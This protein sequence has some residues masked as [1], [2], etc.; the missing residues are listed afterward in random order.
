MSSAD[1]QQWEGGV[2]KGPCPPSAHGRCM[3]EVELCPCTAGSDATY[4]PTGAGCIASLPCHARLSPSEPARSASLDTPLTALSEMVLLHCIGVVAP[5]VVA[6]NSG[7]DIVRCFTCGVGLSS[8]GQILKTF[9]FWQAVPMVQAVVVVV[10]VSPV[11]SVLSRCLGLLLA[12]LV[13]R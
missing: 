13:S 7:L 11:V 2:L 3:T 6:R 5:V 12:T 1:Q 10:S 8:A 4:R 9:F